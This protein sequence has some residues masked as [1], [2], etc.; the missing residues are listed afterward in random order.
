MSTLVHLSPDLEKVAT[1]SREAD[2]EKESPD[3]PHDSATNSPR[4]GS[5][6]DGYLL[7]FDQLSPAEKKAERRFIWKLDLIFVLVGFLGYTFKYLDQVNIQNAY[8]S[9][10]KEV[11]S[12]S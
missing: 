6:D 3:T 12:T 1:L 11:T 7:P 8:V 4:K 9:G 2:P 5:L 10:M